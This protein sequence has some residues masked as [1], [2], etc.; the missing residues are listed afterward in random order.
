MIHCLHT[1]RLVNNGAGPGAMMF[2]S[3]L[4]ARSPPEAARTSNNPEGYSA[5]NR[6]VDLNIFLRCC[7]EAYTETG[8]G[9]YRAILDLMEE[10]MN[11][12]IT[13]QLWRARCS[14]REEDVPPARLLGVQFE[15]LQVSVLCH[16]EVCDAPTNGRAS[17]NIPGDVENNVVCI[18]DAAEASME[19]G[20]E[21]SQIWEAIMLWVHESENSVPGSLME[22]L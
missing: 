15:Y 17:Q 8:E 11:Q 18:P 10:W 1:H 12:C 14:E 19:S 13:H 7:Q 4:S 6:G 16:A 20:E 2:K 3:A 22:L 21:E 5:S 9:S